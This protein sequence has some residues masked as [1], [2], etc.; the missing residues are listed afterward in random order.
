VNYQ[1]LVAGLKADRG[2]N[3]VLMCE[4]FFSYKK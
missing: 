2:Q 3:R 4:F 1:D